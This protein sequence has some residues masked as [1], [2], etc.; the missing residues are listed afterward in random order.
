MTDLIEPTIRSLSQQLPDRV[1]VPGDDR[2]AAATR[3]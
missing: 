1:S 3:I 2:Y